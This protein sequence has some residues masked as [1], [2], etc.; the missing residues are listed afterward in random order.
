MAEAALVEKA[1]G[2]TKQDF[3]T[4]CTQVAAAGKLPDIPLIVISAGQPGSCRHS[5]PFSLVPR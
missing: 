5:T 2:M 4:S 1:E 3:D